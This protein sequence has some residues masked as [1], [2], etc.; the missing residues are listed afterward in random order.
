MIR[1][2]HLTKR[3]AGCTAVRDVTFDVKRGEI[4]GFLGPNGAGKTTTMRILTGYIPATGGDVLV[5]GK[6][7]RKDSLAVRRSI[8]YLP[9]NCPLYPEMRV[10]EYLH[11]RARLKGVPGSARRKRIDHLMEQCGIGGEGRRIIGQLSKGYRQRVGLAECL[12]HEPELLILDEPTIGLDPNQIRD[13][14]ALI[15]RLGEDRTIVLSTHILSE[16]EMICKRVLIMSN[17]RIVASDT[18]EHLGKTVH[19]GSRIVAEIEGPREDIML[20]LNALPHVT[21]VDSS[22][23]GMYTRYG[24]ECAHDIDLRPNVFDLAVRNTWRLRELTI[25]RKSLEDVF[26]EVTKHEGSGQA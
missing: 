21:R 23:L 11:F 13:V 3:Y 25:E 9:E 5:A 8:G 10:N 14:R 4:V 24:L 17:G 15:R 19:G 6:D 20:K 26:V 7:V 1:V 22:P 2:S 16:V 18:P 12:V